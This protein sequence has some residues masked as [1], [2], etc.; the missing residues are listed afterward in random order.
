MTPFRSQ[1][2]ARQVVVEMGIYGPRNMSFAPG[3]TS[4]V[5]L[6]KIEPAIDDDAA[7]IAEL[8][9]QLSGLDQRCG[10][11]GQSSPRMCSAEL[12]LN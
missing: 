7:G 4:G 2:G 1:R 10:T 6:E 12:T 9:L 11:R 3:C 5:R 8:S